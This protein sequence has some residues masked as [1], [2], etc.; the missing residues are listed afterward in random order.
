MEPLRLQTEEEL[1]FYLKKFLKTKSKAVQLDG[2]L[3]KKENRKIM[4]V[5]TWSVNGRDYKLPGDFSRK[6]AQSFVKLTEEHG[7]SAIV[8]K[9]YIVAGQPCG[10]I[11][12]TYN[13]PIGFYCFPYVP[14]AVDQLKKAA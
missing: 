12:A 2:S 14:K 10:L 7:S 13:E 9:E 8:L 4:L 1:Y 3:K 11:L 6:A 5:F